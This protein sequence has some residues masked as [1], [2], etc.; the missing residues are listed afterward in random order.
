MSGGGEKYLAK[1]ERKNKNTQAAVPQGGSA[2]DSGFET[3]MWSRT[4][5][6]E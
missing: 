2:V 3:F 1:T 5:I 6:F 4:S